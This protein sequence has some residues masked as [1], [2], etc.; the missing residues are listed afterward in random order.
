MKQK[1]EI[2]TGKCNYYLIRFRISGDKKGGI[3][4]FL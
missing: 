1:N 3:Y 4:E 2:L